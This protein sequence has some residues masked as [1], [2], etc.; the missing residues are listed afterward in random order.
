MDCNTVI[1]ERVKCL[2][3]KNKFR[4]VICAE[5]HPSL[6]HTFASMKTID[7]TVAPPLREIENIKLPK[8]DRM[9]LSNG[10]PVWSINAG[11]QDVIKIE[12]LFDA[13]RWQE[14][15]RAVAATTS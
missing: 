1:I 15:L 12:L 2:K 7:R 9:Q 4:A 3:T 10:I 13:G 5:D 11:T 6:F 8:V 14:P